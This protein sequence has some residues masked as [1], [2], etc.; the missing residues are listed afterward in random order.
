M[1]SL[2]SQYYFSLDLHHHIILMQNNLRAE[3]VNLAHQLV[4]TFIVSDHHQYV[5]V[6]HKLYMH[7]AHGFEC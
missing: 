2:I 7:T 3:D 4:F 6:Q 1:F 5:C